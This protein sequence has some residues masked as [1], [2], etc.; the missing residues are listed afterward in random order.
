M[1]FID[2]LQKQLGAMQSAWEKQDMSE[3]AGLAHWLK[4]S[5]GTA[6]FGALTDSAR[7]L[8]HL[9]KEHRLEDI[10]TAIDDLQR[11][12]GRIES[13]SARRVAVG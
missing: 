6:G 1:E 9:A 11:L 8:E 10:A 3:L 2:R 13:P 12:V 7:K 4:G 5:G